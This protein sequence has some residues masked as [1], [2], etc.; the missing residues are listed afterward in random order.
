MKEDDPR[1]IAMIEEI[2]RELRGDV[3]KFKRSLC[4][5]LQSLQDSMDKGGFATIRDEEA[6]NRRL[7]DLKLPADQELL[8]Y[9]L[10]TLPKEAILLLLERY[11][12][13]LR[14]EH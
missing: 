14:Q 6:W 3:Q 13:L 7:E 1:T 5:R 2:R 9:E 8:I 10:M 4:S 12:E 11:R